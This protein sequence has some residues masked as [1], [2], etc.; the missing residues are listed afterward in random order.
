MGVDYVT[1]A[2]NSFNQNGEFI[3]MARNV[4]EHLND[5]ISKKIFE[6][7]TMF[8]MTGDLDYLMSISPEYRNLNSDIEVYARN[9][10]KGE[11]VL[12]FGSGVAAHYLAGRFNVFGVVIDAFIEPDDSKG[13]VD[14]KTGIRVIT[15]QDM[16]ANKALYCDAKVVISYSK[17][18]AADEVRRR[19]CSV[20]GIKEA[21]ISVGVFDWRNNNSQYFDYFDARE[22]E[23]FVDCGCFDGGTCYRFAGWCGQKGFEHIYS[24]EAD[25]KNYENCKKLLEPLQKCD[26]YPYGVAKESGKVHF[27]AKSFEDSC[28]VSEED[29]RKV[30]FEGVTTIETVA[31]DEVLKGKNITYLKLD[32]EGAEYD[33]LIGASNLI[34]E[35]RPRMAVSVYHKPEDFVVLADLVL[36]MH[37]D[38]RIS[39]RHYGLD[40]LETI[41]YVE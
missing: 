25:P 21:N 31:L 28:I 29:A 14:P 27:L 36:K 40:E 38:Y 26:L 17:K 20:I 12:I 24:F 34:K 32:V 19:L 13:E 6:A 15:E 3:A 11:H 37:E 41:M 16:I 35:C 33:A 4:Y 2:R 10:R 1:M 39:F 30:N 8:A 9:I 23:V 5:E 18:D 22:N 7:R